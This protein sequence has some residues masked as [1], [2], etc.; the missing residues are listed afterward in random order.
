MNEI[1]TKPKMEQDFSKPIPTTHNSTPEVKTLPAPT[2]NLEYIKSIVGNDILEI[3]GETGSCKSKF[4]LEIALEALSKKQSV[5]FLDTE[6]NL[7]DQDIKKL[8][9]SYKYT[10]IFNEVIK[11]VDGLKLLI[12]RPHLIIIDS[13]GLPILTR[14]AKLS[15]KEKGDAL[16]ALI[17]LMGDLKEYAYLNDALVIVTNQPESDFNKTPG[18]IRNPF[19]DKSCFVVKE[20]WKSEKVSSKENSTKATIKS[21]RSRT[22]G[23]GTPLFNI[24]VTNKETIIKR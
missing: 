1:T 16:L 8:G 11:I 14:Y 22:T 20:I 23:A 6:R 2:S 15:M 10:P 13:V 17:A 5:Y 12:P 4:V 21:F 9:N 19:G 24:E 18:T 7:N 3:F